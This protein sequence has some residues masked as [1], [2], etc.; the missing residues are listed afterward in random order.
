MKE[1]I[2]LMYHD[3]LNSACTKSGFQTIGALQYV[4]DA[5]AFQEQLMIAI[6]VENVQFSFDDGG[7]SSYE[8][9][10]DIL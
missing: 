9:I 10:A 7:C 1:E 3:I 4:I 8:V 2:V 5:D 6:D